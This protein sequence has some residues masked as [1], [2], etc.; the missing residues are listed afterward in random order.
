M[1]DKR[2][3]IPATGL[4]ATAAIA[5]YMVFT[6]HAQ[7]AVPAG[8]YSNAA[9]AEVRDEQGQVVLRGQ[10]VAVDEDDDDIERKATLAPTQAGADAGGE[11]EVEIDKDT[12][13]NQEIEFSIRGVQ[14]G[15]TFTF[16]ID[17]REVGTATADHRGRAEI[18]VTVGSR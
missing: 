9:A 8:D 4:L 13:A 1:S 5:V 11:A 7:T 10:F 6:L 18:E 16:V 12:P 14:A 17:G 15:S 2:Q 3:W